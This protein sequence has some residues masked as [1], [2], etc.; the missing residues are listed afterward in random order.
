[1]LLMFFALLSD[2]QDTRMLPLLAV[3]A[4]FGG[5]AETWAAKWAI[6][7]IFSTNPDA[8][9]S[10]IFDV[11]RFR[12]AGTLPGVVIFP[13]Y[14]TV[15]VFLRVLKYPGVVVPAALLIAIIH[16][17]A[18]VSRIDIRKAV[19]LS[20]PVLVSVV[21][22]EA[23]SSHSQWHV[24]PTS[25]SAAVA[26]GIMLSALLLAMEKRPTSAQLRAHLKDAAMFRWSKSGL[27]AG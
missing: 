18:T 20:S 6:A 15:K 26:V 22:F 19:W 10:S 13:L 12:V 17:G 3:L 21:W 9:L 27:S 5:Y 1:M 23:L 7:G 24:T 11:V 16:Y 25:R 14:A 4:W 2:R 8:V